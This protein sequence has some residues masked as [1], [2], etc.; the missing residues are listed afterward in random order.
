[1]EQFG[2]FIQLAEIILAATLASA[3]LRKFNQPS[4]FAYILAGVFLG[5]LVLGGIDFSF[6]NL[7]FELGVKVITPEV[8]LLAELGTAFLLFSIG[9][10]TSVKKV[11]QVGRPVLVGTLLQVILVIAATMLLTMPSGL[12][13]FEQ[14]LFVGT[15][16]AF[17]STMIVIKLLS[18]KKQ[19]NTLDGRIMISILLIQDFL[20]IIFVPILVNITN[21]NSLSDISFIAPTLGK[22]LV[23]IIIAFLANRLVFPRLFNVAVKE[24]ELFFLTSISTALL[25]I[26]ASY[27][28]GVPVS[29]GAFIGGLSL[30]TLP[31]NLSIL[32]KVRALRDFF[33]TIFFVTLGIE[34]NFAFGTMPLALMAAIVALV[35][36]LKPLILFIVTL[37]SGYGQKLGLEVAVNLAQVSEFGFVI[38]MLGT[39]VM[40][41]SGAPVISESMFSFLIAL[42]AVS[43]IVTPY[44]SSASNIVGEV[45]I[46]NKFSHKIFS[47]KLFS[48]RID[49]IQSIPEK[50]DLEDHVV[51]VG[52]G[53]AGRSIAMKIKPLEKAILVDKDPEVVKQAKE[54]GFNTYYATSED[55]E[56]IERLDLKYAKALIIC[57]PNHIESLE[58]VVAARAISKK[59]PIIAMANSYSD[60][61]DFYSKGVDFVS[62]PPIMG[63]QELYTKVS[64]LDQRGGVC[65]EEK[66]KKPYLMYIEEQAKDEEKYKRNRY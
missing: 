63:S 12:L 49:E 27:V 51:I 16:V 1:M 14:A 50:K 62:I 28:L 53:I 35:F 30:S 11:L 60:A 34:L 29:I 8:R 26:G 4:L 23:L 66:L 17:S 46:K 64:C 48:R 41:P 57:F 42:T 33:L 7:P 45:L 40:L 2:L 5:P 37:L 13:T 20:I 9:I 39:T 54:D 32:S 59:L 43:M 52:A 47:N 22:S 3:L 55:T 58:F 61:L 18:D 6:L 21:F 10:E 56:F 65:F 44:F 19:T 36:L 38:A 31:H 15:I 25:F 24:Q